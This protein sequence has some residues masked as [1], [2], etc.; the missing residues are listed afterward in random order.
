MCKFTEEEEE[1]NLESNRC[2]PFSFA[3][4]TFAQLEE[5]NEEAAQVNYNYTNYV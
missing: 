2:F 1:D 4:I 3:K 5:R